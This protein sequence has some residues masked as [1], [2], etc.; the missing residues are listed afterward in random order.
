MTLEEKAMNTVLFTT[1][2]IRMNQEY[3]KPAEGWIIYETAP[4]SQIVMKNMV[5]NGEAIAENISG[6]IVYRLIGPNGPTSV[7]YCP[8]LGLSNLMN[9]S[10][11][12]FDQNYQDGHNA[13][14]KAI[15]NS[16]ESQEGNKDGNE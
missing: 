1:R 16:F 4:C 8:S 5:E 6:Q 3:C 9:D 11:A 13:F 2:I 12:I 7:V 10:S 15:S 14:V